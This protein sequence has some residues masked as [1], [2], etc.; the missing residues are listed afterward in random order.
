M[1]FGDKLLTVIFYASLA[2]FVLGTIYKVY[3]W[4]KAK[5]GAQAPDAAP[6]ERMGAAFKGVVGMIFS[7]K[8]FT[9]LE[10]LFLDVILGRRQFQVDKLRWIMHSMIL[11][12][13][14]L[15]VI[16]HAFGK[17]VN[18][19]FV[20]E[21]YSTLNPF[22]V[23]RD[24]FA[25]MV[26]AGI[27]LAIVRRVAK[28]SPRLSSSPMDIY[29]II[30]VAVIMCS[31]VLYQAAQMTSYSLFVEMVEY[32]AGLDMYDDE[33]DVQAIE[34]FWVANYGLVSPNIEEPDPD[35]VEMGIDANDS[36]CASCHTASPKAFLSYGFAKMLSPMAGVL[37]GSRKALKYFHLL[38]CFL[39]LA[40]LPFSKMFH[41]ISTPISLI[42][43]RVMD[44]NSLP[45]NIAT[46]QAMEL[47]ACVHCCTCS[48]TC[49]AMMASVTSGNKL[50]LPSEKM[51]SL[52]KLANG[53]ELNADELEAVSY[54]VYMCTN[55]NRCT[56]VCPSG[57]ILKDLWMSV[58]ES[59]IQKQKAQP[60]VLTP[61]SFF[62]GYNRARIAPETYGAPAQKA[63][64]AVAGKFEQLAAKDV[65]I[66]IT[67]ASSAK[68]NPM[69][70]YCF[71]CQTCTTVCPVVGG[72]ENP[73]E[74]L[75]L[76]P[77]QIM[78]SLA[79]GL[80]EM[81]SGSKMIWDCLTCYQCQEHCPQKV[82]VADILYDLKNLA[83]ARVLP[84]KQAESRKT[85]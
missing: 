65:S 60:M 41:L 58:R 44:E 14:T 26:F 42:A 20:G 39:G 49:S 33:E 29:A 16:F 40:Y 64:E 8:L 55:C 19:W 73:E 24:V 68:A 46:R 1:L 23:L 9:F 70:A 36:Y 28:K 2:V 84:E 43:S 78:C 21:Y 66:D 5:V 52:K 83:A 22:W 79:M 62:R 57:I 74:E 32:W 61:L 82:P 75:G 3:G 30:I 54:G 4:F 45:E 27:I 48:N 13:F 12:G 81:A 51:Q 50:V 17:L 38:A 85:K 67:Q 31:G 6:G 72:F 35:M 76:V 59:L 25:V 15:L 63:Q 69:F 77:H 18:P 80:E 37:D 53:G 71:G 47:D 56:A 10:A 7:K 11:W 34:A